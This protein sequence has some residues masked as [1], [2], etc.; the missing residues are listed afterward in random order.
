MTVKETP[1]LAADE[2]LPA[3]NAAGN[4]G[5]NYQPKPKRPYDKILTDLSEEDLQS[6]GVYKLILAK[7][8]ELEYENYELK[9]NDA[10]HRALEVRH[11]SVTSELSHLKSA[12]KAIE[13]L[14]SVCLG[15][16]TC[17]IGLSFSIYSASSPLGGYVI[18]G[19]G[20][21]LSCVSVAVTLLDKKN[22]V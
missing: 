3:K 9:K 10:R 17:L 14:F 19:I 6:P 15:T 2:E 7:S 1:E 8:S 16:G 4:N 20:V 22:E 18:A 13:F 12:K 5:G 11:A 21:A